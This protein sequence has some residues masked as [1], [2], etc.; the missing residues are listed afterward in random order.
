VVGLA[1]VRPLGTGAV[2]ALFVASQLIISV[3]ADRLG[4]FGLHHPLDATR[5]SGVVLVILG[6]VLVTRG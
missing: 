6:T 2:V 1:A 4:L 5:L 3:L